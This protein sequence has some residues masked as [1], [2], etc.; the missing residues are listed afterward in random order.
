MNGSV[1]EIYDDEDAYLV[2]ARA[3]GSSTV[4]LL[5]TTSMMALAHMVRAYVCAIS[6]GPQPTL[7]PHTLPTD[8]VTAVILG[9][10][11]VWLLSFGPMTKALAVCVVGV[12]GVLLCAG[13]LGVVLS[14]RFSCCASMIA[15]LGSALTVAVCIALAQ[16]PTTKLTQVSVLAA[17]DHDWAYS[18]D[19][20]RSVVQDS[21]H[22]CGFDS[23]DDR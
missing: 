4:S 5:A 21:L 2:G 19:A 22:C 6:L 11:S 14:K 1:L 16:W 13:G 20:E 12:A 7:S 9:A 8:Q 18:S 10:M 23:L 15:L 17:M 3:A